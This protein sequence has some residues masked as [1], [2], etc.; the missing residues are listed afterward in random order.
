M[1]LWNVSLFSEIAAAKTLFLSF[2]LTGAAS[3]RD[4][5]GARCFSQITTRGDY[6]QPFMPAA[7]PRPPPERA[8]QHLLSAGGAAA[9]GPPEKGGSST[10]SLSNHHPSIPPAAAA[11]P[12]A[13]TATGLMSLA[14]L[15]IQNA[16]VVLMVKYNRMSHLHRGAQA[17]ALGS[18]ANVSSPLSLGHGSPSSSAV[19][20]TS[21]I[22]LM[23]EAVK[24]AICLVLLAWERPSVTSIGDLLST[25]SAVLFQRETIKMLVPAALFTFQNFLIFVSLAHL[26]VMPFQ[27]VSQTKIISTALLSVWLLGRRL[28]SGQW[29]SLVV[30]TL[31]VLGAQYDPSWIATTA[32]GSG[33]TLP[34]VAGVGGD[35][36]AEGGP[37][38]VLGVVSC[39][40]SGLSSSFAAVYFERV[41]KTTAPSLAIRNLQL[42]LFGIPFTFVSL[43][44]LDVWDVAAAYTVSS[45]R[46]AAAP[47]QF[48][49]GWTLFTWALVLVHALGGLLVAVVV[50]YAD[51]IL[52]G[53]A[54][55]I[56]VLLSGYMAHVLWQYQPTGFFVLG[57]GFVLIS[58]VAYQYCEPP[59]RR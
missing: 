19:A 39:I 27:V 56:A 9:V 24:F 14:A 6:T 1:K 59:R 50:K 8:A 35:I 58:V 23:Q 12:T 11:N 10:L 54:T 38:V 3:K 34:K 22:V 31:G 29:A 32:S 51:N 13:L 49:Q 44:A 7:S 57:C 46:G 52:K 17:V 42:G 47:F 15:V 18:G 37:N 5:E 21:T 26:D 43:L 33:K 20:H 41:V 28:T 45:H 4:R 25:L 2:C 30:L 16:L 55:A 48:W 36:A 53:F 40:V